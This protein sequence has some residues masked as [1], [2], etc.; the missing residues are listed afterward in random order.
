MQAAILYL[1]A[2]KNNNQKK[3][4]TDLWINLLLVVIFNLNASYNNVSINK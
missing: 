2:R 1:F 3:M 4:E